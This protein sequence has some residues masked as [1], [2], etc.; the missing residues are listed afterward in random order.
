MTPS[1]ASESTAPIQVDLLLTPRWIAPVIPEGTLYENCCVAIK[2][3]RILAIAPKDQA[4]RQFDAERTIDLP[5]HLVTPGLINAHGHA[6]MTLLRGF[7]DDQPLMVWLEEYI[8]P[9]ENKWVSGDFVRDGTELAIAEMIKSGTTCFS[10]MYFFPEA[11]AA[12]AQHAG[13]RTQVCFPIFDFPCAWGAGPDDYISKG[14]KI[15]DTFSASDLINI[16]FGP[17]APYTVSDQPLERIA[18]LAEEIDA[19]IQIHLHETR[20]EVNTA[21]SE[22]GLRP[23]E[24]LR[25]LGLLGPKTQCVHM[26]DVSE[27]DIEHLQQ[28]NSHV[29]HCPASNLKL[30][31]G[32]C[33]TQKLMSAGVNVAIGTDGAASNNTLDLLGEVRLAALL[34][35]SVSENASALNAHA[36]LRMATLNGA[37]ALGLDQEIGSI[38]IGKQADLIAVDLSHIS[39]QP[40]YNPVSQLIYTNS[41]Q[42]VSH[43]WVNGKSLLDNGELITLNEKEVIHK[44]KQWA[45][46]IR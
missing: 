35:K 27:S 32:F 11:T 18:V 8:W 14:L 24:R 2:D 26:T 33:P 9:V 5:E 4:E 23:I 22:T 46:Q 19:A 20:G 3:G 42:H 6:A 36:A 7:A 17:H 37:K 1:S 21:V 10:D 43:V 13:I 28:T 38:E 41:A 44:A 40:V 34:S 12:A 39:M 30:A 16:A 25:N 45:S 29:I 31:S 15:H